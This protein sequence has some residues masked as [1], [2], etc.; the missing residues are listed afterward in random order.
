MG[1]TSPSASPYNV[2]YR[3]WMSRLPQRPP[4]LPLRQVQSFFNLLYFHSLNS[5]NS[6]T[7]HSLKNFT[8]PIIVRRQMNTIVVIF[9]VNN[10]I[11]NSFIDTFI[12]SG[13]YTFFRFIRQIYDSQPDAA[14][15]SI[16]FHS[17]LFKSFLTGMTSAKMRQFTR[18][19]NLAFSHFARRRRNAGKITC[20]AYSFSRWFSD[21]ES[22]LGF[23]VRA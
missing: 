5:L 6:S 12:R 7:T 18:R 3:R 23:N 16:K 4:S 8:S 22:M 10:Y 17:F 9:Y 19:G 15:R 11:L 20:L 14:R 2:S 13:R 1:V 21:C